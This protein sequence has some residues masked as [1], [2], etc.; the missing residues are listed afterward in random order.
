MRMESNDKLP[1]YRISPV[2]A[3]CRTSS[4][5]FREN[6]LKALHKAKTDGKNCLD[7]EKMISPIK[8]GRTEDKASKIYKEISD[9]IPLKSISI[10]QSKA[11]L[12]CLFHPHLTSLL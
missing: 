12:D 8:L 7:L 3:G 5:S 9:E 10:P 4:F 6:N 2:S 1:E 11:R